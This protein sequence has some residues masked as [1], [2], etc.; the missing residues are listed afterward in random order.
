MNKT[1]G[2]GVFTP[3]IGFK[4]MENTLKTIPIGPYR[5]EAGRQHFTVWGPFLE[6]LE[7]Q[8]YTSNPVRLEMQKDKQGYWH[9]ECDPLPNATR[10]AFVLNGDTERPDPASQYQPE[11][12]HTAS[13][14]VDHSNFSW[15]DENWQNIPLAEMVQYELHVGTFTPEGTFDAIIPRLDELLDLG[16]NTIELMPVAQFPGSRNW[17]YDGVYPFAVQQSYGGPE[18]LKRLVNACHDKGMA[19]VLDVVYNHLGP[20]GNYL[21]NFGPYFTDKYQT[22]WGSAVNFDDAHNEGVRNFFIRNALFWAEVYHI[23][24]LRLDAVHAIYD[25]SAY[26]FLKELAH[27]VRTELQRPL[28][29]IAESD[30]NDARLIRPV[31]HGGYDLHAQW[32][33]DFHHSVHAL[34]TH[35]RS[36]YYSDFGEVRHLAKMLETGYTYTWDYSTFRQRRHGNSPAGCA[37]QQFVVCT[38]NHDQVGNR[39]LGERLSH[40]LE[41][42]SLKVAAG[43]LLLSPFVPMLFMGQEYAEAAP[44]LYFVSHGDPDLVKAVQEGRKRE[45]AHFG[46]QEEPPDPQSEETFQRSKLNWNQRHQ[47]EHGVLLSLYK[48]LIRLRKDTPALYELSQ[49]QQSIWTS[50]PDKLLVQKRWHND[51]AVLILYNFNSLSMSYPFEESGTWSK[52]L[53]SAEVTWNGP[54][55][56][57]PD[58]VQKSESMQCSARSFSVYLREVTS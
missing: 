39:M 29:L 3:M 51:S 53:D 16:I 27:A 56:L 43:L 33:D 52:I 24:A 19:V 10:Y 25:F 49:E 1:R 32:S 15:T 9:A 7:V 42:E 26:P 11:S 47:G 38:Q 41:F 30:L 4:K 57:W 14:L 55:T 44:F 23:D 5:S 6:R 18:G 35:E 28:W 13:Q 37:A 58:R 20:E 48:E 2:I 36:G 46:W 12:V 17:G 31:Q 40:L 34:L 21:A 22:P 45:F 54:G 50:E 8:L